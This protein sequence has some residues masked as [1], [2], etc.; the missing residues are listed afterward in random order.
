MNSLFCFLP[1]LPTL[2]PN[3]SSISYL[4]SAHGSGSHQLSGLAED[5]SG[6]CHSLVW[7][8]GPHPGCCFSP[9]VGS[10]PPGCLNALYFLLDHVPYPTPT[11]SSHI[12]APLT[13]C[14]AMLLWSPLFLWIHTGP[15]RNA[16]GLGPTSCPEEQITCDCL[17][18]PPRTTISLSARGQ[19]QGQVLWAAGKCQP[20]S[21]GTS[22]H[23]VRSPLVSW[24]R[25]Q[26]PGTW[27][28]G[29]SETP[30]PPFAP[31]LNKVLILASVTCERP[32]Q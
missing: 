24:V 18:V 11:F 12:L 22:D 26:L 21:L 20:V 27:P 1:R 3:C 7:A 32:D 9:L 17:S 5:Q 13:P 10:C 6:P 8:T 29:A 19:D 16:T 31:T 2:H 4:L 15:Q 28:T 14:P 30:L 25:E 23:I